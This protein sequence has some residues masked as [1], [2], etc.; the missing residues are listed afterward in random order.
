MTRLRLFAWLAA[1]LFTA[2]TALSQNVLVN[3][4]FETN[5]PPNFG[6]NIGWPIT[7]WVLGPGQTSNVVKVDGPGGYNYGT[8]GPESDASA[9]GAGIPQHYL[10]IANGDNYFYQTFMPRCSGLVT[11]GGFFSTRANSAGTA[12]VELHEGSGGPAGP[13]VGITN[14]VSLPAGGHSATDPWTGTSFTAAVTAF[15]TYSFV[16]YM[17]DNMN[18]DNGFVTYNNE[19][20][21]P[22]PCCPPW[23]STS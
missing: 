5:P 9:P 17:D 10:D 20:P 13:L 15:Q 8:N 7:P 21:A 23:N 2:G 19:C 3:G 6:N 11:F 1:S 12:R 4:N 14:P 22:D 18:F 16:V